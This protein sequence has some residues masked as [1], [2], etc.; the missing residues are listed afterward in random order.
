M[1]GL[2]WKEALVIVVGLV[3]DR[4][5]SHMQRRRRNRKRIL[6]RIP[7]PPPRP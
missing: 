7:P 2:P 1:S 5:V 6:A 4:I 3:L